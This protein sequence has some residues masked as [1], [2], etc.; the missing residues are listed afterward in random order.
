MSRM[1]TLSLIIAS[2]QGRIVGGV[3]KTKSGTLIDSEPPIDPNHLQLMS[4]DEL[5]WRTM[6]SDIIFVNANQ[7]NREPRKAL[8]WG[9]NISFFAVVTLA[10]IFGLI[11]ERLHNGADK[12][13]YGKA[14]PLITEV[15]ENTIE[16]A[17]IYSQDVLN[18]LKQMNDSITPET[19]FMANVDKNGEVYDFSLIV[20]NHLDEK[21]KTMLDENDGLL[22]VK[23]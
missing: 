2:L 21:V 18:A 8:A 5:R 6:K 3:V 17:N 9:G 11:Q 1:P 14:K 13:V 23:A 22:L 4:S 19:T 7:S 20:T 16:T 10:E 12:V 15:I